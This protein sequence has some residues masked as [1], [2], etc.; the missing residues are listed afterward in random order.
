MSEYY[1]NILK[2]HINLFVKF[3]D[4]E[5][6]VNEIAYII[7]TS[8]VNKGKLILCGNRGSAADSQHIAA[9]FVGR[10]EIERVKIWTNDMK[11][12]FLDRDGVINKDYGYVNKWEDFIFIAGSL[13][14]LAILSQKKFR[15]IIVTNQAGIA[16]GYYTENDFKILTRRF[17][18]FCKDKDIIIFDTFYCP[19]HIDGVVEKYRKV[20]NSRKP[21]SGMFLK[22]MK[23]HKINVKDSLMVGDK[24]TDL[25][26]SSNAGIEMNFLVNEKKKISNSKPKINFKV[27]PN[28][29]SVVKEICVS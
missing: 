21:C 14:A 4:F 26:A 17:N 10:F 23:K 24:I 11:T 2:D 15:I 7:L 8:F 1:K 16:K 12:V 13:E 28:L 22:A 6:K 9:E 25:I 18:S 20:C 29:L 19:H 5:E 3:L 27:R